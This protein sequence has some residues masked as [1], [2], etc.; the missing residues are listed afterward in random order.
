MN[1]SQL[2]P[3]TLSSNLDFVL[4]SPYL[5]KNGV[6]EFKKEIFTKVEFFTNWT[7]VAN[8]YG[9]RVKI[10]HCVLIFAD[11]VNLKNYAKKMHPYTV[12]IVERLGLF[13]LDFCPNTYKIAEDLWFHLVTMLMP[14]GGLIVLVAPHVVG[15][16]LDRFLQSRGRYG[17]HHV[18]I[19]VDDIRTAARFWQKKGFQPLSQQPWE[20]DSLCQWFVQNSAG[21]ILELV[22]RHPDNNSTFYCQNIGG[23]RRSEIL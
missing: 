10:D 12:Q 20:G 9:E 6:L 3:I 23:L 8:L 11:L 21:Q 1:N 18:A 22:K 13:P 2:K 17:V 5:E 7:F 16:Q 14:S 19:R 15:D 4:E